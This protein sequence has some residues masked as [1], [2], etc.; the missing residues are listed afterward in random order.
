MPVEW[1]LIVVF[2]IFKEKCDIRNCSCY[3]AV[4]LLE[5]GMKVVET[6]VEKILRRI[7]FVDEVQFGSM[8]ERGMINA[9]FILERMQKGCLGST[10]TLVM[11]SILC[12]TTGYMGL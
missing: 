10:C 6:V 7:V 4:N 12:Y 9:I 5:H 1:P 8:P 2:P 11:F 3:R